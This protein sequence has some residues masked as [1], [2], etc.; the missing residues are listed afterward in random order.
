MR[1]QHTIMRIYIFLLL[2]FSFTSIHAQQRPGGSSNSGITGKITGTLIDGSTND[3]MPFAAV[4]VR[5]PKTNKDVNGTITDD[6]GF[7]KISELKLGTYDL[8]ISFVGYDPKTESITLTPKSPDLNLEK[9]IMSPNSQQLQ[10]VVIQGEK[11]LIE[12]K[13]DKIVYNAERDVANA[14]G[15]ATDVLRRTPL[16]NVDLDGNVQ[17]R[18]SSNLQIL[19]NGKPSSMFAS[20]PADA[21]K[22]IPADQIKSVEV[23]TS[24]SAKYEGEGTAGIINII[25]KKGNAEGFSGNINTS[26]GTR[27][28]NGVL[29]IN[30]GKGRFGFNASGSGHY[31]W[32]REGTSKFYREDNIGDQLRILQENGNTNNSRLG[33]FGTAG[34]FYDIN[35]FHSFNTGFRIRGFKTD[36]EGIY[37]TIFNDPANNIYQNYQRNSSSNSLF[38]G[39]EWS[40][41]YKMKFPEQEEREFTVAYK[42]DG[43]IQDQDFVIKQSDLAGENPFLARDEKNN[44]LGDN[45]EHTLQLDYVHPV[46]ANI[47]IEAGIKGVIR[48]VESAYNYEIFDAQSG[49]YIEDQNRSN[50]FTYNQD[51]YASYF[52][53]NAKIGK[54]TGV[55]AGVRYEN[56]TMGGFFLENTDEFSNEYDNWLPSITVNRKLGKFNSLKASYSKR[57]QRPGLR[58]INPF[59]QIENNRNISEGNPYL[60]PEITNQYEMSYNSFVKGLSVNTS[61]YYRHTTDII[62]SFLEVNNEG[63]SKNTFKNIGTQNTYGAN[64][65]VS[66]TLFEIWTL[67]AGVDAF[68]Y[69]ISGVIGGEEVSNNAY[70]WNGNLNSNLKFSYGWT[71]DMFG[72]YRAKR[73]TLQGFNPSFSIFSMGVQKEVWEKRGSIGLRI[74]EPF[75]ENK[76]FASELSGDNFYQSNEFTIPFRSFGI[77]FSYK[78]GQLNYKKRQRNSIIDNNDMKD[79][80]DS[81]QQ[82][83]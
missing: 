55:L 53:T 7:F 10:E 33:F 15:D 4:V 51:V 68:S 80:G 21:L 28:N 8:L 6:K 41:D 20:S 17:L 48:N 38:S 72:F 71:L 67:R 73:Q 54:K 14:G 46:N 52:S 2:I 18:G 30:A 40:V 59:Q 64:V 50:V 69:N 66:T 26:V 78:F 32:P 35:A 1:N 82:Q 76:V 44:N 5:D 62:E 83:F 45:Q 11:D 39:Y 24:P 31:S 9:V 3:P 34:A 65:F 36:Q 42:L 70:L 19:I 77:N 29:G 74:V 47:K 56:T 43:N 75:F 63:V 27:M 81:Q 22:V 57:I 16:L 61:L 58:Y 79:G 37:T 13:I 25:T 60:E 49:N 12:N 23:I